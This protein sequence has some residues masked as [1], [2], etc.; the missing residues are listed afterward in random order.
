M[1]T[2]Q[3]CL[4][5]CW[6]I[7]SH[8]CTLCSCQLGIVIYNF[9]WVHSCWSCSFHAKSCVTFLYIIHIVLICYSDLI[10]Y[11]LQYKG[12]PKY[13]G[14]SVTGLE[15][16]IQNWWASSYVVIT[17]IRNGQQGCQ[18]MCRQVGMTLLC[19]HKVFLARR[20]KQM[21][22]TSFSDVFV[23]MLMKRVESI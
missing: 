14:E 21:I 9:I 3:L 11:R 13:L 18:Q 6:L 2:H 22:V 17:T 10:N 8:V 12:T 19:M 15:I 16:G 5:P 4:L 7:L 1:F 20:G 23:I